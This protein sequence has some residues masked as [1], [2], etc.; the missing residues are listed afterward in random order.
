MLL[1][2]RFFGLQIIKFSL[3]S[4]HDTCP[5]CRKSLD[6]VVNS[7][8]PTSEPPEASS[9]RTEQ[10]ERQAIWKP[11]QETLLLLLC[12][13]D[14]LLTSDVFLCTN[15]FWIKYIFINTVKVLTHRFNSHVI[16]ASLL[17][18][19]IFSTPTSSSLLRFTTHERTRRFA[20][21]DVKVMCPSRYAA[22]LGG[23]LNDWLWCH[24]L[25]TTELPVVDKM[26]GIHRVMK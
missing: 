6:G 17:W 15:R 10:Q 21:K 14:V 18:T 19:F 25:I 2:H 8:P 3:L 24:E 9:I 4:Q 5:V 7:L 12:S 1:F 20:E 16:H 23:F 11:G 13:R 26:M 22:L